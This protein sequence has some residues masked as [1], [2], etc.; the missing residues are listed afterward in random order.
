MKAFSE[1]FWR[2]FLTTAFDEDFWRGLLAMVLAEGFWQ[3]SLVRTIG[4]GFCG[5]FLAKGPSFSKG[6]RRD[7]LKALGLKEMHKQWSIESTSEH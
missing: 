6:E 7:K 5:S 2:G 4:E 1:R 3:G